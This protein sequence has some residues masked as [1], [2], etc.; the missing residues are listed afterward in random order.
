MHTM[1]GTGMH[2]GLRLAY[3]PATHFDPG[4][5]AT[6]DD[7]VSANGLIEALPDTLKNVALALALTVLA[8]HMLRS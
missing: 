8:T 2:D 7:M 5:L 6:N 3:Q 4:Q 1:D